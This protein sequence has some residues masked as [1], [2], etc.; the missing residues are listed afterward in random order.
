MLN[1]EKGN[2][3]MVIMICGISTYPG[4][5]HPWLRDGPDA[6]S[7]HYHCVTLVLGFRERRLHC[8]FKEICLSVLTCVGAT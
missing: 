3:K 4:P 7:L 2:Q 5:M 6:G 1:Y 8:I